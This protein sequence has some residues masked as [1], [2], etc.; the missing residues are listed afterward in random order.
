MKRL[1][2]LASLTLLVSTLTFADEIDED[3]A[4]TQSVDELVSKMTQ[5]QHQNRYRYMNA[6]KAQLAT[7]KTTIREE[8]LESIMAQ[9]QTQQTQQ[10]Q[11]MQQNKTQTKSGG[12][13]SG[14]GSSTGGSSGNGN[15]GNGNGGN[16]GSGNGGGNGGGGRN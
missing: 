14:T 16:G 7:Q 9:F 15:G 3:I 8:K 11:T 1:L 4:S 6:I 12:L 10:L 13:G 2:L 5:A